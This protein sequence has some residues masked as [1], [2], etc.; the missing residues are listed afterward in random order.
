MSE[1]GRKKVLIIAYYWPPSGGSGV[2]RWLRFVKNL[3]S[4]GWEP[5][6]YTAKTSN[7]PV[8]DE[9]L[10]QEIPE[11]I[12]TL[13]LEVPEPNELIAKLLFWKKDTSNALYQNQEQ[14]G[15]SKSF[16]KRFLWW[17]RG[18]FFI[19]DARFLWIKPSV[20]YLKQQ[21][22]PNEYDLVVST[23][24]PHSLHLIGMQVAKAFQLP[25]VAD[26]RDPWVSMDYLQAVQLTGFAER[27]HE[28]LEKQV[29]TEAD[30]VLVVGRTMS[31]EFEEK[32]GVQ[33]V[34]IHNGYTE[35]KEEQTEATLDSTFSI[36]H[37]GSINPNR[38]CDDLWATLAELIESTPGFA[39]DLEIKLIGNVA[40][41]VIRSIKQ[42]KLEPY[43][44]KIDY[45]KYAA[46]I[47]HLRAA[48]VLLLP[49]NR[50][51]NAEFV[52]TGKIFEYLNARRPILLLGPRLGDAADIVENCKAGTCCEFD[53]L[54]AIQ[55]A[56]Q[57]Y[58]TRFQN[59]VNQIDSVNVESYSSYELTRKLASHFDELTA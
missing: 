31:R 51:P 46:T 54:E 35:K 10:V 57:T 41:D 47:P 53:D 38:N 26:F 56:V 5:T 4:F 15:T 2:Q 27:K 6:V 32:H 37:V 19:P 44:T 50:V 39:Q 1:T 11:G 28:R 40:P 49:I 18:N 13:K 43:L 48:Q 3:R 17:V 7:Y 12:E 34:V 59:G 55:E 36:V 33:P 24:P 9:K 14:A 45:I 23:G 16:L 25:W 29:I 42:Y 58:Y 21:L 8:Y 52:I 22:D 20:K 30:K